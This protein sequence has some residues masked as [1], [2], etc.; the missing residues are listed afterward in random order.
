MNPFNFL[1]LSS[2][3]E[4]L[5]KYAFKKVESYVGYIQPSKLIYIALDGVPP[6]IKFDLQKYRRNIAR[7]ENKR[8]KNYEFTSAN[9]TPGKQQEYF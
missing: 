6:E 8:P 7:K 9:I 1:G 5:I 3:S 2:A 4:W